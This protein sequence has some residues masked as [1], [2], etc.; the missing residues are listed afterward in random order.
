MPRPFESEGVWLRCA[1]HAHTTS[2][3]GEM[4]PEFLAGHYERAGFDV[5]AITDHWVTTE[6]RS[7]DG[8]VVVPGVELNARVAETGSEAHVL[9]LG[10]EVAPEL[11]ETQYETLDETAGWVIRHGGVAFLAH[12]YWSGLRTPEFERCDA[13]LG[14]EV[15]NA[16]CELEAGRGV[17][18]V[19]WDE[20]LEAGR[21]W[22]AI[23]VDDCHHPGFDSARAW[24][25]VRASERSPA[26]VL[27]ALRD[28]AFYGSTGPVIEEVSVDGRTVSVRCSGAARVTLVTGR[29]RGAAAGIDP[30]GYCAR[31]R[32]LERDGD[33]ITAAELF[34]PPATPYARV[35]VRD[36][37]GGVAWTNP[38][39]HSAAAVST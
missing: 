9:A 18:A 28:G 26:A 7:S 1:L 4:P 20:V 31:G 19:H 24:T 11:P 35:E 29:G 27:A 30:F 37:N 14:L 21:P 39:W 36:K 32:I 22:L 23:A 3:D 16:G 15:Y 25:W 34:A 8:L 13:F 5:L 2:S 17:S 6:Q 12:P 33:G 38:L 10:V